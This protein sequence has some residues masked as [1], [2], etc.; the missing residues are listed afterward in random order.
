MHETD[1]KNVFKAMKTFNVKN[2]ECINDSQK[3]L[4]AQSQRT[5]C[6]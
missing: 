1:N 3:A 4:K 5:H 2:K 6:R